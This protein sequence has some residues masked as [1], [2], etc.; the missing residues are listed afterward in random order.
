MVRRPRAR[1][2]VNTAFTH[3]AAIIGSLYAAQSTRQ[4]AAIASSTSAGASIAIG[5]S[6]AVSSRSACEI[7]QLWQYGQRRSQPYIPN[8]SDFDPG[9][10]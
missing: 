1:A 2:S 3:S 4:P 7:R 10:T 6:P 5:A 8:V 9:S